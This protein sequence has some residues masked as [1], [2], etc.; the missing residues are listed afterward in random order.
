MSGYP[1][2]GGFLGARDLVAMVFRHWRL[3]A[4][5]FTAT[6]LGAVLVAFI[7]PPKYTARLKVLV[8]HQRAEPVMTTGANGIRTIAPEEVSDEEIDSEIELFRSEDLL[9]RVVESCGLDKT[10]PRWWTSQIEKWSPT[11]PEVKTSKAIARLKGALGMERVKKSSFIELSYGSDDPELS[12]RVVNLLGQLYL[13][14]HVALHRS[15][16]QFEFFQKETER[17]RQR[18]ADAESHMAASSKMDNAP[19][20]ETDRNNTL[21]KVAEMEYSLRQTTAS[22]SAARR[23]ITAIEAQLTATP[24]RLSTSMKKADNPALLQQLKS[25]LLDLELKR[26]DLLSKYDPTYV[27]VKEI[28]TQIAQTRTAIDRETNA[29]VLENTTDRNPTYE[30]LNGEL[31]KA[32]A[33]LPT[34][35][36][37]AAA[38]QLAVDSYRRKITDLDQKSVTQQDLLRSVKAEETNYLLYLQ[39]QEEAHISE[40]MDDA[41]ISNVVIS[42]MAAVPVLPSTSPLTI[43]LMGIPLGLL[44]SVGAAFVSDYLDTSF[45]TPDDVWEFLSVPVLAALPA[46]RELKLLN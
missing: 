24:A 4:L 41:R 7:M 34:L 2:S 28:D 27:S 43:A 39:K 21:G 38:T 37:N 18:L 22:V 25:T 5:A 14:K 11:R 30:W 6:F 13:D 3:M 8:R 20:A 10:K 32:K 12:A 40:K 9:R 19:A 23:R 26:T 45:R 1:A 46:S 29:P 33:D 44:L 35:E 42:E 16:G 15:S 31:A 36:A 17:Y